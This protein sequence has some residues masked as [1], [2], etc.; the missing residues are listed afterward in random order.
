MSEKE[1]SKLLEE[2][3]TEFYAATKLRRKH[4]VS[5][6]PDDEE[7]YRPLSKIEESLMDRSVVNASV[8]TKRSTD[9]RG[10]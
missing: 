5:L 3:Y 2:L 6:S 9:R 1:S 8:G 7:G 4:N 10:T